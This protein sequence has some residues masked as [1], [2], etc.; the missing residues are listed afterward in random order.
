[1]HS[2]YISDIMILGFQMWKPAIFF[3][4][5]AYRLLI[6]LKSSDSPSRT[7]S[8][9][10][11]RCVWKFQCLVSTRAELEEFQTKHAPLI[12]LYLSQHAQISHLEHGRLGS[13]CRH[14]GFFFFSSFFQRGFHSAATAGLGLAVWNRLWTN[15]DYLPLFL[16]A[17]QKGVCYP[18]WTAGFL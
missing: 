6:V 12:L 14:A 3:F 13:I 10:L 4:F 17:V 1:M 15:R 16:S 18:A 7:S 11:P 8:P 5:F 2:F 9:S